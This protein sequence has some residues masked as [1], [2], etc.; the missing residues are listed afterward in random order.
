MT[1][2]FRT[3]P[4]DSSEF[5][6]YYSTYTKIVPPGDIVKTMASQQAALLQLV[7]TIS[8]EESEFAYAP[9]KWSVKEVIGHMTDGERVFA[10]RALRV[11]RGDET[12]LPG[13]DENKFAAMG[14]HASRS[15]ADI[16][17]EFDH[18]RTSTIDLFSSFD[19]A[20]WLRRGT[21][22]G[23]PVTVRAIAWIIVGHVDHHLRI[24]RER[25][26]KS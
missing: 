19:E 5:A 2:H 7:S 18:L 1:P 23:H 22:S 15:L 11:G 16:T 8:E 26:L 13:F 12:P 9:G 14:G 21:A 25:Y 20:A 24:I 10:Y 6:A 3:L 4:P 17:S